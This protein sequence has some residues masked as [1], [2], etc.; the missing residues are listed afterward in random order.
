M[1]KVSDNSGNHF[2]SFLL[3]G[4]VGVV[5][6]LLYAPQP[7]EQTRQKLKDTV[8][9]I[10][11]KYEDLKDKVEDGKEK[12]EDVVDEAKRVYRKSRGRKKV[13]AAEQELDI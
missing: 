6:G 3:G 7:G 4:L 5:V 10:K 1:N 12:I 8:E 11:D 13:T 2:F 9:D